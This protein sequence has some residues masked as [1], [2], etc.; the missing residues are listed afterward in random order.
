MQI[1]S[2]EGNIH[3]IFFAFVYLIPGR[4]DVFLVYFFGVH[5][6]SRIA[7]AK[8][9]LLRNYPSTRFNRFGSLW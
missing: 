3:L 8:E 6:Q 7:F 1:F 5:N 4:G 2:S 9:L